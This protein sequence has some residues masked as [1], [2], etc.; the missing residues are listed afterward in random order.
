MV[1][2]DLFKAYN[3][4]YGHLLGDEALRTVAGCL[5]QAVRDPEDLACRYGGEEFAVVLP[6]R[7]MQGAVAVA[8]RFR[9]LLAEAG[10]VHEASTVSSVV[11]ASIG[12]AVAV[13]SERMEPAVLVEAADR[14]LYRAKALGRD[15]VV[16]A[17]P[18]SPDTH[19]VPASLVS[20]G[21]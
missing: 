18:T 16:V 8:V 9:G 17:S 10:I 20:G 12:I 15:R 19:V 14:A 11:T 6:R 5:E 7:G 1:D 4:R 21:R 13:A 2:V 3:D